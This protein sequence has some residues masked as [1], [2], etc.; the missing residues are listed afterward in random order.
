MACATREQ[1]VMARVAKEID[2]I[3]GVSEP[4]L[5]LNSSCL[6]NIPNLVLCDEHCIRHL[7]ELC[8]KN[9]LITSLV[10]S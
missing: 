6:D 8:L 10:S 5:I 2:L 9:N 1:R 3:A 7:Q 4:V